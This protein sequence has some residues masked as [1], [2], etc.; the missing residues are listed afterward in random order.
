[1]SPL[2]E[3]LQVIVVADRLAGGTAGSHF[4]AGGVVAFYSVVVFGIARLVRSV[5]GGTRYQLVEGE[6]VRDGPR[7]PGIA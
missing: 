3:S 4:F 5:L 6:I 1:M 2:H 7:R